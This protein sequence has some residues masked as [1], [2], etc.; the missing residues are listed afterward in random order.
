MF[1]DYNGTEIANKLSVSVEL[2]VATGE[3]TLHNPSSNPQDNHHMLL[4]V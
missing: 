2:K 4:F 1:E 3:V